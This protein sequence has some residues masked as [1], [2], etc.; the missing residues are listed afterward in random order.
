MISFTDSE[1]FKCSPHSDRQTQRRVSKR[2]PLDSFDHGTLKTFTYCKQANNGIGHLQF[3][4]E[5]KASY[6]VI[7]TTSNK[8]YFLTHLT[9]RVAKRKSLC[10][11][12]PVDVF[13]SLIAADVRPS[14][15][16][17]RDRR[18]TKKR[19]RSTDTREMM[20]MV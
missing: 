7:S 3:T 13:G 4:Q 12:A 10:A 16:R 11:G 2:V 1:I 18:P 6:F 15:K 8:T 9:W 17:P 14:T 5:I 20:V 19:R